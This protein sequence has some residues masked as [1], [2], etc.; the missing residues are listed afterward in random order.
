[1]QRNS[2]QTLTAAVNYIQTLETMDSV[3]FAGQT[4][5]FS[6]YARAGAN[7]SAASS[8]LSVN[9][10]SGTGTDQ[11]VIY[12]MT[13][14]AAVIATTKTLTTTW[15]RFTAT[16]T[17]SASATQLG[18]WFAY[19]PVGTA[20]VNDYF[21][22]T[23]VQLELG[24][25]ATTFKRSNGA[26]GTIQGE[27]AACQRYY[28]R[29]TAD[30]TALYKYFAWG[31]AASTTVVGFLVTNPVVMRAT[32]TVLEYANLAIGDGVGNIAVT[33]ASF[34]ANVNSAQISAINASVSS[35][36]T[37]YRFYN[38]LSNNS[39]SGYVGVGAEL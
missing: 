13:G 5:T 12:T 32:P 38:L 2:G 19:T 16:G 10:Y 30:A 15:Q 11:N 22:V 6:F 25:V 18:F 1:V 17:V 29:S 33:S 28:W 3:R 14:G 24:S 8:A 39:S 36:A 26:G 4:V 31:A 37:Q 20:G 34:G 23:G 27:L 7:F 9:V 35:G 21:E